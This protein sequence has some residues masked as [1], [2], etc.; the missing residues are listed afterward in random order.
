[1]DR[2]PVGTVGGPYPPFATRSRSLVSD[3]DSSDDLARKLVG[4][5]S[6]STS[7]SVATEF[8]HKGAVRYPPISECVQHMHGSFNGGRIA[9]HKRFRLSTTATEQYH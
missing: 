7:G 3:I 5:K 2:F 1:M 6:L 4:R 8:L 9:R